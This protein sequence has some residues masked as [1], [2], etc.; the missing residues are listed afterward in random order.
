MK[1]ITFLPIDIDETQNEKFS[2]NPEC[3]EILQVYGPF[4]QKAGFNKPWIGYFAT[5]EGEEEI[6]GGGGYKG[7][8]KDGTI[9][10]AYGVF[11]NYQGQG[12]GTAIC[13]QLVQLALQT[14][15]AVRIT[16]RTL[17]DNSASMNILK[18]NGFECLG[19]VYDEED[20]DVLEW[21]YKK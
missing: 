5:W 8:P 19:V 4:Y 18:K 11:K 1:P 17:Q 6:I 7:K 20:G 10:V 13:R 3:V 14:D 2:G 12:I 16:A 15:P 21:E 9:E